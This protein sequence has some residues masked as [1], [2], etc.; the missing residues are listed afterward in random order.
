MEEDRAFRQFKA[1]AKSPQRE[2]DEVL[3]AESCLTSCSKRRG[4]NALRGRSSQRTACL[5]QGRHWSVSAKDVSDKNNLGWN[6]SRK[7]EGLS[8]KQHLPGGRSENGFRPLNVVSHKTARSV[9]SFA[10]MFFNRQAYHL[11]LIIN[12]TW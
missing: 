7:R 2:E 3:N 4:G 12:W 10:E 11:W 5:A 9:H 8:D 6:D 1:A